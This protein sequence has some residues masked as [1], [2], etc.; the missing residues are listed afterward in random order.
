MLPVMKYHLWDRV[1]LNNPN[2]NK[3][4]ITGIYFNEKAYAVILADGSRACVPEDSIIR[5]A[6]FH[7]WLPLDYQDV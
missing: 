7:P 2:S 1:V 6:E 3:G 5:K 4:L